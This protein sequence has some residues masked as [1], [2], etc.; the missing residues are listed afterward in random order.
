MA[1]KRYLKNMLKIEFCI[2]GYYVKLMA[3]KA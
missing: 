3:K 2:F 1:T